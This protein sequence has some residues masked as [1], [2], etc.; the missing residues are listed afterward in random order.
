M[1][2][3]KPLDSFHNIVTIKNSFDHG[4]ERKILAFC[5]TEDQVKEALDE[6]AALAGGSDIIKLILVMDIWQMKISFLTILLPGVVLQVEQSQ[7][8]KIHFYS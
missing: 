3:T 7:H 8:I 5:K 4:E 6:G 1:K 2:K